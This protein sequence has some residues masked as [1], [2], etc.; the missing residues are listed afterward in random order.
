MSDTSAPAC[1]GCVSWTHGPRAIAPTT[2][3]VQSVTVSDISERLRLFGLAIAVFVL[4]GILN[5]WLPFPYGDIPLVIFLIFLVASSLRLSWRAGVLAR[6]G[7][8]QDLARSDMSHTGAAGLPSDGS[9]TRRSTNVLDELSRLAEQPSR[10]QSRWTSPFWPRLALAFMSLFL[11]GFGITVIRDAMTNQPRTY[12][13]LRSQGVAL[14]AH[15]AGCPNRLDCRLRLSYQGRSRTWKYGAD[16]PQF[17]HLSVGAAV[18]VL[19]D[20]VHPNIVYTVHDVETNENTGLGFAS[21]GLGFIA[22]GLLLLLWTFN[23]VR[24]SRRDAREMNRL[25]DELEESLQP[26][27]KGV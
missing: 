26:V 4:T 17:D 12:R 10:P 21:V 8:P 7:R 24:K 14:T 6:R 27:R 20:P 9:V 3:W 25:F 15:F 16:Y 11:I 13:Q 1:A 22:F 23:S 19:L 18:P 5:M 2:A